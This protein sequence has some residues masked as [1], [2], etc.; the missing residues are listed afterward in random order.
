MRQRLRQPDF[1]FC[2]WHGVHT[3]LVSWPS[4]S[5]PGQLHPQ[6]HSHEARVFREK[7]VYAHKEASIRYILKRMSD[8]RALVPQFCRPAVDARGGSR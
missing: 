1:L 3:E 7:V 5:H 4:R 8:L 6:R 2:G